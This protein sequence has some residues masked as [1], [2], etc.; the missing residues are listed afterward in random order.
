MNDELQ[1]QGF[2][3]DAWVRHLEDYLR[4]PPR[5]GLWLG[6]RFGLQGW[7]VLEIAGGSCRDSRHLAE[8]GVAAIGSDFDRKTLEWL[9]QRFPASPL[10]LARE[11]ASA[12]TLADGAVD[13]TFHNGFWVLFSDDDR[14][15]ALL[16]EQARVTRRVVV[17]MVHNAD[18]PRI[19]AAFAAKA[20][21]DP[22]YAIRF[23]RRAELPALVAGSGIACQ[24]LSLE[25]FGA[26][27]DRALTWPGALGR[28]A[29][30]LVPRLY[31]FVPW[32]HVE[33]I[34]LV[35]TL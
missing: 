19:V 27:I 10:Q 1:Q 6:A 14:V 7:K 5:A 22:L 32:R 17:A 35:I 3:E 25:K 12:M 23:F 30:W 31:R 18:N 20:R 33:R 16:R 11:D 29:R 2:W 15:R 4:S 21:T 9:A 26:P 28:A 8:Q 34:A 13:L 24:S